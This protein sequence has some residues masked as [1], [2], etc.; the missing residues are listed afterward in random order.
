V[1]LA[2]PIPKL[3]KLW[4]LSRMD[5]VAPYREY[6]SITMA[7]TDELRKEVFRLRYDV[8]CRELGW[9]DP[10]ILITSGVS[11]SLLLAFLALI[12]PGDEV[13]I[14]DP[15]FVIYKHVINML[16]GVCVFVDSYPDF[17]LPLK[18]I[19]EAI[20]KRTKLVIVNSPC[21]PTGVVYST[22]ALQGLAELGRRH[23]LLIMSDEIMKARTGLR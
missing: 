17:G 15:Y 1:H 23:D 8:Y 16:G 9:E 21:N 19:E 5:L 18:G 7:D 14:P 4:Q 22:E 12:D 20:T 6:F 10:G 3:T 13:I 2:N 11:G